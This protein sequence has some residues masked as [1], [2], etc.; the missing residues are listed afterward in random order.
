MPRGDSTYIDAEKMLYD[1]QVNKKRLDDLRADILWGSPAP[2][3]GMPKG[4]TTSNTTESKVISSLESN[5]VEAL[6]M[7]LL[8]VEMMLEVIH[9]DAREEHLRDIIRLHCWEGRTQEVTAGLTCCTRRH[10]YDVLEEVIGIVEMMNDALLKKA[11]EL[12]Q[13]QGK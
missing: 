1:Y 7:L 12:L 4:N 5:R 9:N 13:A 2:S 11:S 8:P 6:T 10:I 3:D